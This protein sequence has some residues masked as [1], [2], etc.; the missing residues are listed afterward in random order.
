MHEIL[1]NQVEN[2]NLQDPVIQRM[3]NSINIKQNFPKHIR[4]KMLK[5]EDSSDYLW[6]AGK[7]RH[8][9]QQG[10]DNMFNKSLPENQ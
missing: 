6:K 4:A 5:S 8:F 2:I 3:L 9:T 10:E 7:R 1:L